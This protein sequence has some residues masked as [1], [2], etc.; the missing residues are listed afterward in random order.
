MMA[1]PLMVLISGVVLEMTIAASLVVFYLLQGSAGAR[2]ADEALMTAQSGVNDM[3]IRL[4]RDKS[5]AGNYTLTL[6]TVHQAQVS[7]CNGT[8]KGVATCAIADV[9]GPVNVGKVEITSLGT[10]KGKNRCVR[11]AYAIDADTGEIRLESSSE[12]A[13]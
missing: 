10:V 8:K 3:V 9:C 5:F 6:D 11:A 7:V 1:L 4:V 2:N 13:L 12:I